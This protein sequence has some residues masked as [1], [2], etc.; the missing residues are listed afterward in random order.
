MARHLLR[1]VILLILLV[2]VG[3]SSQ[4]NPKE[5]TEEDLELE[6]VENEEE[7]QVE[8]S[9]ALEQEALKTYFDNMIKAV[10]DND[11]ETFLSYQDET[12]ELFYSEQEL[13]IEGLHQKKTEGWDVSVIVNNITLETLENGSIELQINMKSDETDVSNHITYPFNKLSDG[14]IN[15]YYLPSLENVAKLY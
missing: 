12:N 1:F 4:T 13:W 2:L 11:R 5:N 10:E 8:E 15:L 9:I 7:V 6:E 14:S 3:G